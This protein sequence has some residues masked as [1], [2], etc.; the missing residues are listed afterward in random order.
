MS[1]QNVNTYKKKI[2]LVKQPFPYKHSNKHIG[3]LIHLEKKLLLGSVNYEFENNC[4]FPN[5]NQK[6]KTAANDIICL[7]MQQTTCLRFL[8]NRQGILAS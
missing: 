4:V 1:Q 3:T 8:Y 5:V 7:L 6:F 2:Y